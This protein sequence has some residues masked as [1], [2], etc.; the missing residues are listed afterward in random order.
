MHPPLS[1]RRISRWD[2]REHALDA[3]SSINERDESEDGQFY[4]CILKIVLCLV[5]DKYR[6]DKSM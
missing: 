1:R 2:I 6:V 3:T 4:N 5:F